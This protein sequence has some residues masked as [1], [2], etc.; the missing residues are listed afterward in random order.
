MVEKTAE[1]G[2]CQKKIHHNSKYVKCDACEKPF[3]QGCT[4][5]HKEAFDYVMKNS[6]RVNWNCEC[7]LE[8]AETIRSMYRVLKKVDDMEKDFTT[9]LNELRAL[10]EE[11]TL[12]ITKLNST[13]QMGNPLIQKSHEAQNVIWEI[14]ERKRRQNNL[15]IFGIS[16]SDSKD[17]DEKTKFDIEQVQEVCKDIGVKA[18]KSDIDNI[19]RLG[20][21]SEGKIR[22]ILLRL[23]STE[24]KVEILNRKNILKETTPDVKIVHDCTPKQREH[25]KQA[26]EEARKNN[27]SEEDPDFL[28]IT[29]G[30]AGEK[31]PRRVRKRSQDA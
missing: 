26:Y 7:N 15:V 9:K 29:V 22:P 31:K 14:E 28:W 13:E 11:N 16:E 3:H 19:F 17:R 4:D 30:R 6:H 25:D 23:N 2:K 27:T 8:A 5:M 20:R 24:K 10:V 1:C 12:K 21:K 18:E